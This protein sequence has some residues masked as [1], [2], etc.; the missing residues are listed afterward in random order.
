MIDL[1]ILNTYRWPIHSKMESIWASLWSGLWS[2]NVNLSDP[3]S[4]FP[5]INPITSFF[6]S[7]FWNDYFSSEFFLQGKSYFSTSIFKVMVVADQSA[8]GS[9]SGFFSAL[10]LSF[11][12]TQSVSYLICDPWRRGSCIPMF[13][14]YR[15]PFSAL[16]DPLPCG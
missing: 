11:L 6:W 15:L 9:S 5:F 2:F 4:K 13:W 10:G 16:C 7:Y 14:R 12:W 1:S 8:H 3:F